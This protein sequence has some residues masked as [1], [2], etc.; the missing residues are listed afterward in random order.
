MAVVSRVY[1]QALVGQWSATAARRVDWDADTIKC[2]LHSSSYV[3]DQDA[4]AFFTDITDEVAG[5]GYSA[6]GVTITTS[7]PTYDSASNTLRLDGSDAQWTAATLTARYAVI[8][9]D[10]GAAATSPVLGYID[11]GQDVS[12]VGGTFII[13]WDATDGILR[14]VAA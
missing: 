14:V 12:V 10:T 3:P 7:A 4:H 2:S 13:Q 9:K 1:G 8:R 11:F 5:A 6:G